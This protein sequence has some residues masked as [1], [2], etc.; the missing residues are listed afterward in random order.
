MTDM[1]LE[2]LRRTAERNT[3]AP[4]KPAPLTINVN[5]AALVIQPGDRILI[6]HNRQLD[7]QDRAHLLALFEDRWSDV[8]LVI[9]DNITALA[10]QRPD[11][12]TEEAADVR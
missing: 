3:A 6:A 2:G 9:L 5:G 7:D 4:A 11:Q 8:E 1:N 10:I 12:P